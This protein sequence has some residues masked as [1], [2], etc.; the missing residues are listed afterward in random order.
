[1]ADCTDIKGSALAKTDMAMV[2]EGLMTPQNACEA[3]GG[4][5]NAEGEALQTK[6]RSPD[7][8]GIRGQQTG[9][10]LK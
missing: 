5:W 1:M 7:K 3:K 2:R 9:T 6:K 4:T 8:T 10:L